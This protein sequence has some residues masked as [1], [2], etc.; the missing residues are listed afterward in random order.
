MNL[1]KETKDLYSENCKM[2]LNLAEENTNRW[3]DIL[4]SEVKK[5]NKYFS[6]VKITILL[7]AIYRFSANPFKLPMY[8]FTELEQKILKFV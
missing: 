3:K 5:N 1:P 6:I 2:L 7:K 8:F 4:C